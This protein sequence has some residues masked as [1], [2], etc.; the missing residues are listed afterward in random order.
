MRLWK[1]GPMTFASI[2]L[3]VL[4]VSLA[5]PVPIAGLIVACLV[6]P[7]LECGLLYASLGADR[8]GRPRFREILAVFAAPVSAQA[9]VLAAGIFAFA[10][11]AFAA[12]TIADVNFLLPIDPAGMSATTRLQVYAVGVLATLPVTFV[13]MAALFDGESVGDAFALSMRAFARNVRPLLLFAVYTYALLVVGIET[14]GIGLLLALP[15]MAAASYAAWKD[16]FGLSAPRA[17]S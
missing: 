16:I 15:L 5:E 8:N 13:P 9:S 7:L 17:G 4:A 14:M 6:A 3:V 1:R 12:W 11:E 10:V 2:A